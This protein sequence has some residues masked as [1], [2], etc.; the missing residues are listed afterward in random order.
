M[1][2]RH[3]RLFPPV[4]LR[5]PQRGRT[6]R[7]A[8]S[9]GATHQLLWEG[10]GKIKS[11]GRS[12]CTGRSRAVAFLLL[13]PLSFCCVGAEQKSDEGG[14]GPP[15]HREPSHPQPAC[16]SC[17]WV[18]GRL[19]AGYQVVVVVVV[20]GLQGSVAARRRRWGGGR[21]RRRGCGELVGFLCLTDTYY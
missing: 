16:R 1:F 11:R 17:S 3:P 13:P 14:H 2:P 8:G 21:R 18:C 20:E 15:P 7:Q 19:T 5:L 12:R 6:A 9:A 4:H 10:R